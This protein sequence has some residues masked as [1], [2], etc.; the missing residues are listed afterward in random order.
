[1][2][3]KHY[4]NSSLSSLGAGSETVGGLVESSDRSWVVDDAFPNLCRR[5]PSFSPSDWPRTHHDS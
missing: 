3:T 2:C 1:M 4:K 5:Y